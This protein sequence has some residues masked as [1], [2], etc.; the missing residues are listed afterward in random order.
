MK[1]WQKG[2]ELP[3]LKEL[4]E[5]FKRD[6]KPYTFG[7]FGLPKERDVATALADKELIWTKDAAGKV[8]AAAF[9]RMCGSGS[10]QGDFAQR[11]I[12][13]LKGDLSVRHIAGSLAG[14]SRL[15]AKL[16]ERSGG[17]PAWLEIHEERPEARALAEAHGF[18]WVATKISASSDLK[19]LYLKNA[20]P[21]ARVN[22]TLDPADAAALK[23]VRLGFASAQELEA[24]RSELAAFG[25]K[26]Q[27]H[28]SSYN[29][30]QSWT[31]FALKGFDAADPGFIIK[32]A[33]MSKQWKDENTPRL[34]SKCALTIA[35]AHFPAALQLVDRIPGEKE[36]VR[37]M[38]LRKGDG[39]LTRHADITDREAGTADGQIA[40][41]HI[42]IQTHP[43]CSFFSWTMRGEPLKLH[44]AEASLS[45]LDIRKPHCVRNDSPVERIHLVVDVRSGPELRR[46][47]S[48]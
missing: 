2:F 26:W 13:F 22:R 34:A 29:K 45:Y 39:E 8:E 23:T 27:Q 11:K 10:E 18:A 48:G 16:D 17:K 47:L 33:E 30:R 3:F 35:A 32:P 12:K 1:E 15:L 9:F 44:F 14:M 37:L 31:S 43:G 7:A 19:G 41:L 4:A 5:P 40:R 36:R 21:S 25:P 6:F 38:K 24:V 28:Y 42:P 46:W 20:E